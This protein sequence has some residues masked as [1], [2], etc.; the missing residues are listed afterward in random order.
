MLS[1]Y[2]QIENFTDRQNKEK[3]GDQGVKDAAAQGR[4]VLELTVHQEAT[5]TPYTTVEQTRHM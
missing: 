5:V 3:L 4:K 1:N 2:S